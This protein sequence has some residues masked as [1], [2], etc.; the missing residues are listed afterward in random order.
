MPVPTQT[1]AP[2]A[3]LR[4]EVYARLRDA[5]VDGT[6]APDEQLR[7]NE[8]AQWLG[9]SRTPVR[10]AMLELGRTGL[11]RALPGRSTVVAPLEERAVRDAQAVVA[12][13][14]RIAVVEAVPRMTSADLERMRAANERFARAQR[15]GD[16]DAALAADEEFHAVALEVSGNAAVRSVISQYEPVLHR[17]ERLRFASVEGLDS[18]ARHQHLI[19]LCAARDAEGAAS[20]AEQTW[21][22]LSVGSPTTPPEETS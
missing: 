5:I 4:D 15:E 20:V 7:D 8:I 17:A 18:V 13:M 19:D 6:L 2:R 10:E 12:A 11:V 21:R 1:F 9:V 22:S 16:A 3:L 14:H